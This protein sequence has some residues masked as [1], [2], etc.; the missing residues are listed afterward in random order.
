MGTGSKRHADLGKVRGKDERMTVTLKGVSWVL[1]IPCR[2]LSAGTIHRNGGEF[3]ESGSKQIYIRIERNGPKIAL[4]EKK[5]F[6]TLAA[7]V[8]A[9]N[10]RQASVLASFANTATFDSQGVVR[11]IGAH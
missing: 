6:F 11:Y 4:N 1:G 5:G 9:S 3:F 10:T 7:S 8:R 2:L